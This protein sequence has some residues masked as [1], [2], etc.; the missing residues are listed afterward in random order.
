MS[1]VDGIARWLHTPQ[2][3]H[4][5]APTAKHLDDVK[6]T[7]GE[8]DHDRFKKENPRRK[9]SSAVN[10]VNHVLDDAGVLMSPVGP[11]FGCPMLALEPG[12]A[13]STLPSPFTSTMR[14]Q[15][16]RHGAQKRLQKG[17]QQGS[18]RYRLWITVFKK[19]SRG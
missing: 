16:I 18:A 4:G 1:L 5:L 12:G 3:F 13:R 11:S 15:G 17:L 6:P 10:W 14:G 9:G 8:V 19:A 2:Q 7:C